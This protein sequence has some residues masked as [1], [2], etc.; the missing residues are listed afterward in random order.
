MFQPNKNS[1][2]V[3][4]ASTHKQGIQPP[5]YTPPIKYVAYASATIIIF[6]LLGITV[7]NL[8]LSK[9]HYQDENGGLPEYL[10]SKAT[11][12]ETQLSLFNKIVK[13]VAEQPTT[14]DILEHKNEP[15]SLTW[16]LQMRRYLHQA[17]GVTL[18][19]PDGKVMGDPPGQRLT[20]QCLTDMSKINQ[21]EAIKKPAVH[22]DAAGITHFDLTSQVFDETE[23]QIGMLFVSF[24]ADSLSPLLNN[25][26]D[27]MRR[28]NLLDGYG[29]VINPQKSADQPGASNNTSNTQTS[30]VNIT[31]TDWQLRLIEPSHK[32]RFSFLSLAIFNGAALLLTVGIIGFLLRF[33]LRF[34]TSDFEQVKSL[35]N[36]LA[37]GETLKDEIATPKLRETAEVFPAITQLNRSFDKKQQL[38]ENQELSDNLTGLSNRRQFNIEFARAYDF[39]RRGTPVCVVLL[40]IT[41]LEKLN[42]N[43]AYQVVK[44]LAKTLKEHARKVDLAARLD[45]GEFALLMFG[46]SPEGTMP[47]LERLCRSFRKHQI[48]HPA[49]PKEST[50]ALYCG[51]TRIHA[52]RDKNAAEVLKR[53]GGALDEAQSSS[54]H[55][56]VSA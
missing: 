10:K 13:H 2:P 12:I 9:D 18:L 26:T 19:T 34:I 54:D 51:Y 53:A 50:C 40:R 43:Q 44:V 46:A 30:R 45:Y 39:A 7:M 1:G 6:L 42:Q 22:T 17:I 11:A 55:H 33:I 24:K 4:H 8:N 31:D 48:E 36:S 14:Q 41:G 3:V 49:I 5:R 27:T 16:A 38:L 52:H 25:K 21:H 56:I 20:P 29:T 35:L 37:E 47:C 23:T 28:L 32:L 15:E